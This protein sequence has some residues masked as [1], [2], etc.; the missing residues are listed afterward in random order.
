V[1]IKNNNNNTPF[2]R[3]KISPTLL[4]LFAIALLLLAAS[5]M[6]FSNPILL[7]SVQAT[8]SMSFRTPTPASGSDNCVDLVSTLTFDANGTVS[9]S[10]EQTITSGTFKVTSTD[11]PISYSG[12]ITSG[13]ANNNSNA[14]VLFLQGPVEQVS[15]PTSHCGMIQGLLYTIYTHCSTSNTAVS[16][17]TSYYTSNS[18]NV[19]VG[20]F[21]G[22]VECSP[23]GGGTTLSS[24]S[25]SSSSITGSSQD[26]DRDGIP[27]SSDRCAH[28]S[29]TKCFKEGDTGTETTQQE[30]PSSNRTGN[31][32]G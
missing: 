30:Q 16:I 13:K 12:K 29:N 9:S 6:L 3:K 23:V 19:P 20:D 1:M 25:S 17:T 14:E 27:D 7:Q 21:K 15:S 31:H 24:S 8:T 32:T 10:G 28:N 2:V 22:V 11:A 5:P 18:G 26:G 4:T